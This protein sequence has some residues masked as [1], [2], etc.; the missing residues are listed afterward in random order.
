MRVLI[1]HLTR[2]VKNLKKTHLSRPG[3]KKK[4]SSFG[5]QWWRLIQINTKRY[6]LRK[7]PPTK[8]CVAKEAILS[9]Q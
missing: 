4:V 2:Q 9:G 1:K 7:K 8:T 6:Y 5:K 3:G